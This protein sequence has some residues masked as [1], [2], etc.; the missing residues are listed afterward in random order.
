MVEQIARQVLAALQAKKPVEAGPAETEE[1]KPAA[2]KNE[3]VSHGPVIEPVRKVNALR[4]RS[5]SVL[6]LDVSSSP[7][8]HPPAPEK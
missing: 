5:S 4:F 2:P 7:E 3:P 1:P 6:G 8:S